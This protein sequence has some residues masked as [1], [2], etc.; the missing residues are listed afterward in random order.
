LGSVIN[1]GICEVGKGESG[2]SIEGETDWRLVNSAIES[3][4]MRA[5]SVFIAGP[6]G[7]Q[8]WEQA[9]PDPWVWHGSRIA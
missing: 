4:K 9:P 1:E 8:N 7:Y 3:V 5:S 2:K 6:A